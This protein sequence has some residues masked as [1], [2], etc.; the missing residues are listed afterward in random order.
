MDT[1][2]NVCSAVTAHDVDRVLG[3]FDDGC[4]FVDGTTGE[5]GGKDS[6]IGFLDQM[7]AMFPDYS[8]R[9][10]AAHVDGDT[11]G[12]VYELT[13]TLNGPAGATTG[14][15]LRW[16]ATAFSTFAPGSLAII[17]DV[18]CFDAAALEQQLLEAQQA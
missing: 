9:V 8:P 5:Q 10:A 16:M 6:L 4:V 14:K 3:Y 11:I 2:R 7:Y 12:V 18:Y 1:I 15:R 17:R 13:G